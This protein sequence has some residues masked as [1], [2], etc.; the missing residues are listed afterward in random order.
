MN[1]VFVDIASLVPDEHNSRIHDEKNILLIQR[2]YKKFGQYR[3]FVVQ[4]SNMR[5]LVG[6]GLL[7]AMKQSGA[8]GKVKAV[9][10]DLDDDS[11]NVLAVQDNRSHDLSA[12][13]VDKLFEQLEHFDD[14]LKTLLDFDSLR[15]AD[16][17]APDFREPN[18]VFSDKDVGTFFVCGEYR[19]YLSRDQFTK[20]REN[21][22]LSAGFSNKDQIDEIRRRIGLNEN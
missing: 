11:A 14:K 2:N 22:Q 12:F 15:S 13:D 6:N 8:T 21:L 4:K 18:K 3:P 10:L 1:E 9:I 19:M 5:V 17:E 16:D 20:W 7:E